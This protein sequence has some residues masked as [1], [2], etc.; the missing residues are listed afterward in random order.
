MVSER[1]KGL[2][3]DF[4]EKTVAGCWLLED[5]YNAYHDGVRKQVSD[6]VHFRKKSRVGILLDVDAGRMS[7]FI[8]GKRFE[9]YVFQNMPKGPFWVFAS[10][11]GRGSSVQFNPQA[12]MPF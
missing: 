11:R 6:L 9:H 8:D 7:F 1:F 4:A 3:H 12:V 10:F 5:I 2:Q